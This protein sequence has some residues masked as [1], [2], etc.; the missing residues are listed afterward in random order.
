MQNN[1]DGKK[2][3]VLKVARIFR[4]IRFQEQKV[5]GQYSRNRKFQEWKI[6]FFAK[7]F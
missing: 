6:Y 4:I 3:L 5:P 2:A 1:P 7:L